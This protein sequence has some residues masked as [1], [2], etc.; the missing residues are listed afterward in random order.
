MTI[1]LPLGE[2]IQDYNVTCCHTDLSNGLVAWGNCSVGLQGKG[3]EMDLIAGS[4]M[5][6]IAGSAPSWSFFCLVF[7]VWSVF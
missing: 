2:F 3:N 4:E 1:H 7:Y 6:L 5:D